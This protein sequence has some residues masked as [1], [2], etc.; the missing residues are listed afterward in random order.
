MRIG[1]CYLD[2]RDATV[3]A[4]K[5]YDSMKFIIEHTDEKIKNIHDQMTGIGSPG[6]EE[7]IRADNPKAGE[8]K[9]IKMIDEIDTIKERYRQALEFMDWFEPAWKKLNDDERYILE[10]SYLDNTTRDEICAHLFIEKD[11]FYKRRKNAQNHLV[12]L[13]YGVA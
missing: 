9:L 11:A 3:R 6:F 1:W 4:L 7:H 2:K 13:L 10:S 8:D 5:D 12:T